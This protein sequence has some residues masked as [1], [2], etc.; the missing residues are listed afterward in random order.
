MIDIPFDPKFSDNMDRTH[1]HGNYPCAVCGCNA[2]RAKAWVHVHGGGDV[3]V[4]EEESE[5]LNN[6]E[7]VRADMGMWPIGED[8]RKKHPELESYLQIK[9]TI[10]AGEWKALFFDLYREISGK[11]LADETL[12]MQ[13]EIGRAHV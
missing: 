13:E 5:Q 11:E 8:C 12:C 7:E 1:S 10:K 3:I 2:P 4:T 9:P 6:S